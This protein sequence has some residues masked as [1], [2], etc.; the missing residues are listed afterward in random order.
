MAPRVGVPER[1]FVGSLPTRVD[2]NGEGSFHGPLVFCRLIAGLVASSCSQR[3]TIGFHEI[4]LMH[5]ASVRHNV[6]IGLQLTNS[7]RHPRIG[8]PIHHK[9]SI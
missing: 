1:G 3:A 7:E 8:G 4:R 9:H 5:R 6:F 2:A